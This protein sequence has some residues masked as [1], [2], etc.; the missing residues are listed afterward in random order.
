MNR[1]N[2][3]GN[4]LALGAGFTILP[5]AGRLWVP[6]K[7]ELFRYIPH[8]YDYDN[9]HLLPY[10]LTR[11]IILESKPYASWTELT[12]FEHFEPAA[13]NQRQNNAGIV[14]TKNTE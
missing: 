3:I 9:F 10:Y 8:T 4:L 14:T 12:R 13:I 1:R 5:G 11:Q 6:P 2:F 7:L